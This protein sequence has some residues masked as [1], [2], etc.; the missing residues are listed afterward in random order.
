MEAGVTDGAIAYE[1]SSDKHR[2]T[3]PDS[4]FTSVMFHPANGYRGQ[5]RG[6]AAKGRVNTTYPIDGGVW[7][8]NHG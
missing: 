7:Q 2:L 1:K 4:P 6:Y 8:N 3:E 5:G